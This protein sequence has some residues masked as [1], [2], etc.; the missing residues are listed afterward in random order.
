MYA[1]NLSSDEEE[2]KITMIF[3]TQI[4]KIKVTEIQ[5]KNLEKCHLSKNRYL[6]RCQV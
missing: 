6:C 3:K 4:K 2:Q 1:F 5:K